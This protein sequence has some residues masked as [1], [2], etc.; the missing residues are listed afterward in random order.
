MK[1]PLFLLGMAFAL[2][3][4]MYIY[5]DKGMLMGAVIAALVCNAF[6][7][8]YGKY[9]KGVYVFLV[10]MMLGLL[11]AFCFVYEPIDSAK[12]LCVDVWVDTVESDG[13]VIV[14]FCDYQGKATL[15]NVDDKNFKIGDLLRISG[16]LQPYEEG[17]NPGEFNQR[18]FYLSRNII[19]YFYDADIQVLDAKGKV[20]I[21]YRVKKIMYQLRQEFAHKIDLA[22]EFSYY[23]ALYKGILLGDKSP[24]EKDIKKLYQSSGVAHILAISGLHISLIAGLIYKFLRRC[25]LRFFAAGTLS[26]GL[27]IFYG[28]MTGFGM[29][30]VRAVIMIAIFMLAEIL[31][32]CY[33]L[34]TA[35]TIALILMILARPERLLDGGVHLSF[36]A[37][38]GVSLGQYI[39]RQLRKQEKYRR[40]R[41]KHRLI[42]YLCNSLIAAIAIS[43]V[44]APV[45]ASV[46]YEIPT[47]GFFLNLLVVPTM[48]LVVTVGL[49]GTLVSFLSV[50]VANVIVKPGAFC[51]KMYG[52]LAEQSLKLPGCY[53]PT[54]H[55][56]MLQMIIYYLAILCILWWFQP[57]IQRKCREWLYHKTGYWLQRKQWKYIVI[58]VC[59]MVFVTLETVEYVLY[60]QE[61]YETLIALDVGQGQGVCIRMCDGQNV[62]IDGGSVSKSS[63][64]EYTLVPALKYLHM[65]KVDYWFV[66]HTDEDHISGLI[67]ILKEGKKCGIEI[68]HLV[69]SGEYYAMCHGYDNFERCMYYTEENDFGVD[70]ELEEIIGLAKKQ[71]IPVLM[72][73]VGDVLKGNSCSITCVHPDQKFE[74]QMMEQD[75]NTCSLSVA[76]ES[77]NLSALLLGDADTFAIDYMLEEHKNLFKQKYDVL[78]LPHH[79]SKYSLSV[80]LY[81]LLRGKTKGEKKGVAICSC[82][83]NNRYGHPHQE[84][85]Q[86]LE[87]EGITLYR[88]DVDGAVE[89]RGH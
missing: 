59:M 72:M 1:R 13:K 30:T 76:Y 9:K 32:D 86:K 55:I 7:Y 25:H 47:Y 40:L 37:I 79:G 89:I 84:V 10:G 23:S 29:A 6:Y 88:T 33:D 56:S 70:S 5:A 62:M 52:F 24:L 82:G 12:K 3:E 34:P 54:G 43:L 63:V 17:M 42:F 38:F 65:S 21:K 77:K 46:Y 26:V 49:L 75:K 61:C 28:G 8:R 48:T 14:D 50:P 80:D 69:I 4:A 53:I 27:V 68:E 18:I 83:K 11:H 85:L 15:C 36:G 73:K 45:I 31:G 66:S 51:L 67:Y 71:D 81:E 19:G 2:G 57:K 60:K 22:M 87:N 16:E 58:G 41:K 64:G 44:M 20:P 74:K 39:I 78:L 35:M